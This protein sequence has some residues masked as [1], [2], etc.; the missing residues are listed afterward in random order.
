VSITVDGLRAGSI[1]S[2]RIGSRDAR[3]VRASASSLEVIVPPGLPGGH[4]P[5]RIDEV[6]GETAFLEVGRELATGL[7]LVDNPV[8]DGEGNLYATY[9]GT[10]AQRAPVTIYRIRRSGVRE[11]FVTSI[12]HPTSMVF[13]PDAYLYVTSRFEATLH[14]VARDGTEET[15][16]SDLGTPSG[17]AFSPDGALFIGDRD[18]RILRIGHD[19][20]RTELARLPASVAAFHL[21][22]AEDGALYVSAPT[23]STR[24]VIYRISPDGN[25]GAWYSGFGRPQ[26]LAFDAVGMLYVTEALAGSAGVFRMRVDRA[27]DPERVL[28]AAALVGL[29]FDPLGGIVVCSNDA[30]YR[31]DVPIRPATTPG[32]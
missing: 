2:V 15:I 5:V 26:G 20:R 28:A 10:R 14:R 18:G 11:P 8:F 23:L 22:C 27:R 1:P 17:L 29:C 21:A 13:G 3:V 16:A 9:S 31:L 4:Q 25:V 24:D 19:G 32:A 6:S 30:M 7:H 12:A